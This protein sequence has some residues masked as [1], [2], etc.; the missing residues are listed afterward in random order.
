MKAF[1]YL[2]KMIKEYGITHVFY[3]ELMLP[4]T[5]LKL[6]ELGVRTI[7]A[8]NELPAGYMADGYARITNRPGICAAQ[9]IGAANMA[10]SLHDAYL[11]TSPV[12]AFTGKKAPAFQYR[13]AYQESLHHSMYEAVTKANMA[14]DDA[15]ALPHVVRQAFREVVTGKPRPVHIDVKGFFALETEMEEIA[16]PFAIEPQFS[17]YPAN[18]PSAEPE[19]VKEA[20]ALIAASKKPVLIVGRGALASN[21]HSELKELAY[22]ADIPVLTTP[23][24]KTI[25]D[26]FSPLW[27]GIIGGYGMDCAN[28]IAGASDL[29][30]FVGTQTS[31]QATSNWKMPSQDTQCIQIDIDG[32]ELG[33]SYPKTLGLLGDAKAVLA[34]LADAVKAKK[35]SAWRK[36]VDG[37]TADTFAKQ[38]KMWEADNDPI[39]TGRLCGEVSKVLPDDAI[40]VADTGWS[41]VWGA[42]MIRMKDTQRFIR[43]AG[44]LGWA[45]PGSLGVKCGAPDRTVVC[46]T[47]DG[48]FYGFPSE[49]ETA[50]REGINTVT[51]INNNVA[52]GQVVPFM[53]PLYEGDPADMDK[54]YSFAP[55]NFANVAKEFGFFAIRVEKP[56][57]IAPALEKAIAASAER[58]ALVEVVTELDEGPL[59]PA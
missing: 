55:V 14:I 26:E 15:S 17:Y 30:I 36:E 18:R 1:E 12:I 5:L 3:Q 11:G 44:T 48:A 16:E 7:F 33:R 45:F 54:R 42:T 4:K 57:D 41:A 56:E 28:R 19:K 53:V 40:V 35:H 50:V 34:Q 58:P 51:V 59:P 52:L 37:Y 24:G 27:G 10:A 29:A 8:H 13:N 38:Q 47:G 46:F 43:A 49:M 23:D 25:F 31:D 39:K 9:S 32:S 20:A 6:E 22:K 2:A 21:A